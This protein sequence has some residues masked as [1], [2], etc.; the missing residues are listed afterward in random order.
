MFISTNPRF[1]EIQS[2]YK[3]YILPNIKIF[4]KDDDKRYEKGYQIMRDIVRKRV[5]SIKSNNRNLSIDDVFETPEVLDKLIFKSGGIIRFLIE[6]INDACTEAQIMELDKINLEAANK[7]IND[8]AASRSMSI[9]SHHQDELKKV[10][11][12]KM[13]SG[14]NSSNEMI[15]GQYI[16]AYRNAK[17]W[18]DVHPLY[19]SLTK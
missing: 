14:N 7:A 10:R 5:E 11:K 16:V 18:F 3:S 13:P 17:I 6:L 2:G 4:E 9:K 8:Y 1:W 15:R 12:D 19:W